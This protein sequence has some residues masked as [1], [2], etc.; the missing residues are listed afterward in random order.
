[1]LAYTSLFFLV[2]SAYAYQN[3]YS[4][5]STILTSLTGTSI[6]YHRYKHPVTFWIDQIA[7][8]STILSAFVYSYQGGFFTFLIPTIGNLW[9][10]YV[11]FYGYRKKT[12]A[13]HP[14]P[15]IADIWHGTIHLVSAASYLL[16]LY[17]S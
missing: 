5:A 10:S 8:Y 3:N 14:D 9:N 12:L 6:L 16:V 13:F 11:Y 1:M 2:P 7:V 4:V 17:Y 15:K